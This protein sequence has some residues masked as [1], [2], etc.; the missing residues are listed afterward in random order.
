MTAATCAVQLPLFTEITAALDDRVPSDGLTLDTPAGPVDLVAV[1]RA[2]SGE[3]IELTTAEHAYVH[4]LIT[5]RMTARPARLRLGASTTVV[6]LRGRRDDPGY[7]DVVYVGRAQYS[8][9]WHLPASPL[10]NPL[11]IGR[12]G[13]AADVIARYEQHLRSR[14]D[15]VE[16]ARSL[17]GRRLG[18]WCAP[19]PCHADVI[20]R[21]ADTPERG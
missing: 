13:S 12:D 15:L 14:P 2:L 21:I 5:K 16:L 9:G 10:A 11:R 1:D 3:R 8:G 6:N 20:A 17:R 18:C 4:T 7:A 19:Q